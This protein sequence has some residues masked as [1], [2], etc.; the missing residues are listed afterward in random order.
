MPGIPKTLEIL[1]SSLVESFDLKSWSI[2]DDQHGACCL[3]IRWKPLEST[4]E[5]PSGDHLQNLP[6][7]YKKKSPSSTLRDQKRSSNHHS[8]N[9]SVTTR[10]KSRTVSDK[11]QCRSTTDVSESTLI[12]SPV[13]VESNTP[14]F[15]DSPVTTV[16][17]SVIESPV[18]NSPDHDL[19]KTEIMSPEK[20]LTGQSTCGLFSSSSSG[21][22][23]QDTREQVGS[24]SECD[25]SDSVC[26]ETECSSRLC[27]YGSSSGDPNIPIFKCMK[28]EDLYVCSPCI[29]E[30]LHQRHKRHFIP[31]AD[32][33]ATG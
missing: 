27:Y 10:S 17:N 26:R 16:N 25:S 18:L 11:E 24:D 22:V 5:T 30:G 14:V 8:N 21:H 31:F 29:E 13:Q 28:C 1:L 20:A 2:Y 15:D 9:Y 33:C 7:K 3:K 19:Y 12:Q 6:Q 23:K 32:S 4:R